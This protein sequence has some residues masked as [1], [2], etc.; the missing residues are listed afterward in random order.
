MENGP[1]KIMSFLM[2]SMV[3]FHANV[4]QMVCI[5]AVPNSTLGPVKRP[6]PKNGKGDCSKILHL[7]RALPAEIITCQEKQI[8][9]W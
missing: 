2:N 1:V 7:D 5:M 3:M 8:T 6:F 9:P 4:Y